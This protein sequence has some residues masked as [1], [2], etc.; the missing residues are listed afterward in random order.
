MVSLPT[1]FRSYKYYRWGG[2]YYLLP[3]DSADATAHTIHYYKRVSKV[4]TGATFLIP[5][6]FLEILV[7]YAEARYWT[8][9][10]QQAKAGLP[11]QEYDDILKDMTTEQGRRSTGSSGFHMKDPEDAR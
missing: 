1:V 11:F 4:A 9:I 10:T 3:A 2:K 5:D 6:E 7:A 8:S